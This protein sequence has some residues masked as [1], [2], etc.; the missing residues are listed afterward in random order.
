MGLSYNHGPQQ[1]PGRSI[2]KTVE[3][4]KRQLSEKIAGLTGFHGELRWDSSRPDGQTGRCLDISRA[5]K[6]FG[7]EAK[8]PF[9]EGLKVTIDWYRANRNRL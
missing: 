7:F 8:T 4:P 1:S 6:F 2:R 9:D 3:N 5:K